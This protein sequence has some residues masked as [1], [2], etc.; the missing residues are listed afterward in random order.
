VVVE[1]TTHRDPTIQRKKTWLAIKVWMKEGKLS[2]SRNK[3]LRS[4]LGMTIK[5]ASSIFTK[6]F[7][8]QQE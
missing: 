2:L 5:K 4:F 1:A 7:L 3:N 6:I 8:D